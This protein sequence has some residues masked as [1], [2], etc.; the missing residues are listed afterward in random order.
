MCFRR[1]LG[2]QIRPAGLPS[3]INELRITL[4]FRKIIP[5]VIRPLLRAVHR[6]RPLQGRAVL[7]F[8][9]NSQVGISAWRVRLVS[10]VQLV[11]N[12]A[13]VCKW[14]DLDFPHQ[15]APVD[16]H[17]RMADANIARDQG[18]MALSGHKTPQVAR[19]CVKRTKE[20]AE[21]GSP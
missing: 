9:Q 14:A 17:G 6:S 8:K 3:S 21:D 11:C 10:E 15:I 1:M 13:E 12:S 7:I 5:C 4:V 19:L 20:A 18:V 16:L 2:T